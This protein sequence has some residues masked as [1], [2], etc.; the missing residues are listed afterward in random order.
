MKT[1]SQFFYFFFIFL[2]D[3]N[4][5]TTGASKNKHIFRVGTISQ[6]DDSIE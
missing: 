3:N 4:V 1:I 5:L 2:G 6:L